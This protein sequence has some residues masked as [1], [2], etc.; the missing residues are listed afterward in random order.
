MIRR[1][2]SG[3]MLRI[4]ALWLALFFV[5]S[6]DAGQQVSAQSNSRKPSQKQKGSAKAAEAFHENWDSLTL[7]GSKLLPTEVVFGGKYDIPGNAFVRELYQLSWR[8]GDALDL[9]IVRPRGVAKP[10]VVLYLYSFP[11]DTERFKNDHWCGMTTSGGYAAVGFVSALTGHRAERR[12]PKEWFVSELQESLATSAHDVQM[13]LNYLATRGDMDMDRVGMFGQGSGGA[14]GILASAAD[15]RIKA[16]DV[17]TPW[18]DWPTW[19]A[20]SKLIEEDERAKYVAPEFL[21]RVAPLDPLQWLPKVRARSVRIQNVRADGG[22][23]DTIEEK[24]EGAA[25]DIAEINQFGDSRALVPAAAGGR[26]LDWIKA[27]LQPDAKAT[28]A[29]AKSERIHFY[30]AKAET[31]H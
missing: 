13:V 10:P 2:S 18:G 14:I 23:P 11:Q 29:A 30:P 22:V 7:N 3:V 15:P 31:I 26:L 19:L 8:P 28:L 4:F 17:L 12:P 20:K 5:A 1:V 16:L 21:A 25:P 27:Q 6:G 9:Y 24:I